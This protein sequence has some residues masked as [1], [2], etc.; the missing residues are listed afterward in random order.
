MRS[1][2]NW[3]QSLRIN[4][5]RCQRWSLWSMTAVARSAT[6]HPRCGVSSS[7]DTSPRWLPDRSNKRRGT[8]SRNRR[9]RSSGAQ[10][11]LSSIS[12]PWWL[13]RRR[14]SA[15]SAT[16]HRRAWSGA[17]ACGHRS[18]GAVSRSSLHAALQWRAR[19]PGGGPHSPR[20]HGS[21]YQIMAPYAATMSP[22][23][24]NSAAYHVSMTRLR[25][26]SGV[27]SGGDANHGGLR[28]QTLTRWAPRP[29]SRQSRLVAR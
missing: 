26:A 13:N 11:A 15:S 7:R 12:L 8:R 2:R 5:S 22:I 19:Q 18:Y 27:C 21:A 9:R 4:G 3:K 20:R 28:M 24:R 6:S 10:H 16:A 25:Q 17:R 29:R 14:A 23:T 1:G